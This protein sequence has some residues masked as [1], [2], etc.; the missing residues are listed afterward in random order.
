VLGTR[1]NAGKSVGRKEITVSVTL[2]KLKAHELDV[3]FRVQREEE[4]AQ[5]RKLA[6]DWNDLYV[7]NLVASYRD[8]E[9]F[10]IDGQQRY[11][12]KLRY[13]DE[14]DYVFDVMVH[15]DLTV[16]D[17]G[18]M[19]LAMNRDHKAVSAYDK[20]KV[21]VAVGDPEALEVDRV[22]SSLGLTVAKSSG[23]TCLGIAATLLR[24]Q[25]AYGSDV[26]R[27]SLIVNERMSYPFGENPWDAVFIEGV[28][29]F[30]HRYQSQEK[31]RTD[32]LVTAL[33]KS[34]KASEVT[35]LVQVA[36]GRAVN[37]NRAVGAMAQV[38]FEEYNAGLRE[39]NRLTFA[40]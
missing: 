7:G 36:R 21:S 3:D 32:R 37:N 34:R 23:E 18:R 17:E 14:P 10:L 39:A 26:L 27:E 2:M 6:R 38:L 30:I 31:F 20:Y 12:T 40:S 15:D 19:F 11:V 33:R 25:K 13:L 9:F 24:I 1:P 5:C 8:G 22:V 4:P 28:A 29:M 35:K 16:E